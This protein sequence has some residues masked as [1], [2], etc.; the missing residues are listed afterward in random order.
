MQKAKLLHPPLSAV[1]SPL[2]LS[3]DPCVF[4]QAVP[5]QAEGEEL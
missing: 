5:S 3:V 1:L 2:G 4:L